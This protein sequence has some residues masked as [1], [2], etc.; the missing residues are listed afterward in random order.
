ME[1]SLGLLCCATGKLSG[2]WVWALGSPRV[3]PNTHGVPTL[4]VT[5]PRGKVGLT[6]HRGHQTEELLY[7]QPH[8][9]DARCFPHGVSLI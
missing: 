4:R 1:N 6:G 3:P 7:L 8:L 2:W 5:L 9:S